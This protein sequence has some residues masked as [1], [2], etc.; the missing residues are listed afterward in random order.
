MTDQELIHATEPGTP[1]SADRL[2]STEL[3]AVGAGFEVDRGQHLDEK[4]WL[5]ERLTGI[6]SSEV[7]AAIGKSEWMTPLE[8]WMRKRHMLPPVAE[9]LPMRRGKRYEQGAAEEYT[10]ATGLDLVKVPLRRHPLYPWA[11][12]SVDRMTAVPV[13][14]KPK[15]VELKWVTWRQRHRWGEPGTDAAPDEYVFQTQ[16]QLYCWGD[17]VADEADIGVMIGG[18][19][20]RIYTVQRHHALADA[21]RVKAEVFWGMVLSGEQPDPSWGHSSTPDLIDALYRPCGET[22][23][24]GDEH[25]VHL[26]SYQRA[27]DEAKAAGEAKDLAK[28]RIIEA[29]QTAE[30]GL[31]SDGSKVSR[32]L[33]QR[34]AY[35]VKASEYFS[36]R[37]AKAKE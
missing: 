6:G 21:M 27:C 35:E 26:A 9:T 33:V 5:Q 20:F 29:M 37:V 3:P 25:L 11:L 23:H 1:T 32:K 31:F 4:A 8:L 16:W 22:V 36:F 34:R 24:L 17:E 7:A 19:D 15:I 14:G 28:A 13:N 12:S 30:I 2:R 10:D 18:D